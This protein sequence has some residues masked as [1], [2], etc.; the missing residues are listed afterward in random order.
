MLTVIAQYK[1]ANGRSDE[2]AAILR[3]H[4]Q[5]TRAEPGCITFIASRLIDDPDSF[6][7]FEQYVDE[8]A[9]QSHRESPHFVQNAEN[10]IYP[11]LEQRNWA[12][13]IQIEPEAG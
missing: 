13:Y 10:G 9:F 4:V 1:V 12:R 2:V 8:A 5:A 11:L 6:V 7:L 3:D